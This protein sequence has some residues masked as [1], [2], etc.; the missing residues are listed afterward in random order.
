[1][2][3]MDFLGDLLARHLDF[4]LVDVIKV[5]VHR[6]GHLANLATWLAASAMTAQQ[7]KLCNSCA[8]P[9]TGANIFQSFSRR[10]SNGSCGTMLQNLSIWILGYFLDTSL[11]HYISSIFKS[12]P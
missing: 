7:K 2:E 8:L 11:G 1:M 3:S 6:K 4:L 12:S 9:S 5:L 10:T